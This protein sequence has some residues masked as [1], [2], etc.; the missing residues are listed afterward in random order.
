[1]LKKVSYYCL[2][3]LL[4]N[5][6]LMVSSYG[7]NSLGHRLVAQIAYHHLTPHTRQ[8]LNHYNHA[9]DKVYRPQNL[10]NSA[11]WLDSLRYQNDFWLGSKHYINIPFSQ[12]GTA[13]EP[14]AAENA[15]SAIKAAE[16]LM[17]TS[18]ASDFDKGFTLRLLLHVAGDIHQPLHAASQFSIRHPHGDK[19]G[20]LF[21]LGYN[22][23]A[24]N[25]HAYWDKGGGLLDTKKHYTSEQLNRKAYSIEKRWPCQP[26]K[27]TL[28][29]EV[30]ANES[31]QLAVNNAYHIRPGE[32]PSRQYQRMVKS[33]TEQR[34]ALAGCRLASLLNK[35]A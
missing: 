10:I 32:K 24:T 27:M 3:A 28:N 23:I 11:A 13:L 33:L 8:V 20:N 22:P 34:L 1:M 12:D 31:H 26:K 2:L 19:G 6:C 29:P 18:L 30:W 4:L 21:S 9:L 14:P 7:W 15:V 35:L 16:K 17:Q 25:L 5:P